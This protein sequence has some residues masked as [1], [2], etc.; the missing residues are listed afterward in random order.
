M[1]ASDT[2]TPPMDPATMALVMEVRSDLGAIKAM[3]ES[4]QRALVAS[5]QDTHRRIDDMRQAIATRLDGHE[6]DIKTLQA[7]ERTTAIK[8][9]TAG[10]FAGTGAAVLVQAAISAITGGRH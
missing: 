5:Q 3:L 6:T 8:A 10:A 9:A 7:N 2:K 4:N 1:S